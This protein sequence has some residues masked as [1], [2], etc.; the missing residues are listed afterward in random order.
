MG[1]GS[2][3]GSQIIELWIPFFSRKPWKGEKGLKSITVPFPYTCSQINSYSLYEAISD[4]SSNEII[5]WNSHRRLINA[6]IALIGS[7]SIPFKGKGLFLTLGVT[8]FTSWQHQTLER[9]FP[10]PGTSVFL[11]YQN[12]KSHHAQTHALSLVLFWLRGQ[13]ESKSW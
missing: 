4:P 8:N 12:T 1:P 9:F 3:N 13:F 10:S 5:T 2:Q 11:L 7:N 6:E